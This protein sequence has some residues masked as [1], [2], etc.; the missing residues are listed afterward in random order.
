MSKTERKSTLKL[1]LTR[2]QND[3][4]K[5]ETTAGA[6]FR[7]CAVSEV[8]SSPNAR[9][10][11]ERLVEYVKWSLFPVQVHYNNVTYS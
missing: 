1:Q 3:F 8:R 4:R 10:C 6:I 9:T 7:K 11:V 5:S 2:S